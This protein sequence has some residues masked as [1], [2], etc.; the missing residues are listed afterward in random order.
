MLKS[1]L[2][3][4]PHA[5]H[6]SPEASSGVCPHG[7]PSGLTASAAPLPTAEIPSCV[8][9][10]RPE[11]PIRAAKEHVKLSIYNAR[12]W[13]EPPRAGPRVWLASLQD[14]FRCKTQA[15]VTS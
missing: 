10:L 14:S 1:A 13:D 12:G 9:T 8:V 15:L 3:Q 7:A 2:F 6:R 5:L 4:R 11:F